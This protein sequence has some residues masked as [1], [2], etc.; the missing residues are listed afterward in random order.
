[1]KSRRLIWGWNL[2]RAFLDCSSHRI[3]PKRYSSKNKKPGFL[4]FGRQKEPERYYLLPGMGGRL[5]LKKR[6]ILLAWALLVGVT[7][8]T[9]VGGLIYFSNRH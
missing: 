3:V 4:S 6:R 1:M 7:A 9:I 5:W 8:A 2:A